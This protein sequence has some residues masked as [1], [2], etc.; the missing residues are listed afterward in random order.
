MYIHSMLYN[1]GA[2]SA[3]V[4]ITPAAG[5]VDMNGAFFIGRFAVYMIV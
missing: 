5:Y 4:C 2:V 1:I 3:L